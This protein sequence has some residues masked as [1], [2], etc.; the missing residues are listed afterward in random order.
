MTSQMG[1]PPADCIP[2]KSLNRVKVRGTRG[3]DPLGFRPDM[4]DLKK[5]RSV[6]GNRNLISWRQGG[7]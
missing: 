2:Q 1:I 3:F 7:F 4:G 5:E 6:N